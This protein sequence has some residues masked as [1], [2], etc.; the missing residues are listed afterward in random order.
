[1]FAKMTCP[2]CGHQEA[3]PDQMRGRQVNCSNC[4]SPF[5][6]PPAP[7]RLPVEASSAP[8]GSGDVRP[9]LARTMLAAPEEPIRYSCPRCKRSM[10]SPRSMTGE[11]LN[12]PGCGQRL[13]VPPPPAPPAPPLNKT[14]LA[15]SEPGGQA[16]APVSAAGPA[17]SPPVLEVVEVVDEPASRREHCLECGRSLAGRENLLT[18]PKCGSLFCC[19]GCYR[20]HE[21]FAHRR[22]PRRRDYPPPPVRPAPEPPSQGMAVTGL[23]LGIAGLVA[24][25]IPGVGMFFGPLLG[26]LGAIFSG[27]GLGQSEEK[28]MAT[29]GLLLSI[30]ALIMGP[31]FTVILIQARILR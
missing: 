31:L 15:N 22:E 18:C 16:P 4:R 9:P 10:E 17:K 29:T 8:A 30:F 6:A 23:V 2:V 24:A 13:Q 12:C 25:F 1:M 7:A 28:G 11:K 3:V 14:I 20:N 27:I 19:A 21:E 5:Q 26:L